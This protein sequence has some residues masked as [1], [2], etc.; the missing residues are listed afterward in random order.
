[1]SEQ[2]FAYLLTVPV[3]IVLVALVIYPTAYSLWI[4]LWD[5]NF[6]F[7]TWK[8]V[9]LQNYVDAFTSFETWDSVRLTI[10]YVL[11][12]TFI[13]GV[14]GLGGALLLNE[15]F[16]GKG[17][18]IA[19][20]ILPWAVSTY[21]AAVIWRYMYNEQFGLFNTLLLG[22]GLKE[23][24]VN[25]LTEAWVLPAIALAHSWQFAPLGMYFM[26]A[27][28]QVIPPDMYKLARIDRLGIL[29]RFYSVTFPYLKAPMF[30]FLV[31]VTAEAAKV[32]DIIY[33]LSAGGPGTAS[34]D[35][36]YQIYT[37]SFVSLRI[38]VG[39]AEAWILMI[40]ITAITLVYFRFIM[41]KKKSEV[42]LGIA[43]AT[44]AARQ[45]GIIRLSDEQPAEHA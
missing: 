8:F 35:L 45:R 16:P 21:A 14:V 20:V 3:A 39:A 22:L 10:T 44:T 36:V 42:I 24:P 11:W 34:H 18:L 9:G 26:L 6:T 4:S 32:F 41:A 5:V 31:L 29:G 1:M 17:A 25:F 7:N 27:A 23:K 2:T 38:G 40:L 30:I 43:D 15:T 13:S 33:F 37:D 19:L 28:L 12:V